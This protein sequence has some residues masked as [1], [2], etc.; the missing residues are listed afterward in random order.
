MLRSKELRS[1]AR[2]SDKDTDTDPDTDLNGEAPQR[3]TVAQGGCTI[4]DGSVRVARVE[5]EEVG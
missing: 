2:G 4:Q 3:V 5:L 1:G